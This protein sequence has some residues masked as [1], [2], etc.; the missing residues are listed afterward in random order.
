MKKVV[1][2]QKNKRTQN[3]CGDRVRL[4]RIKMR[5]HQIDLAAAMHVDYN[6]EVTRNSVSQI[7]CNTRNVKDFEL[8]VL[9]KILKVNPLWLLFG[10]N[11]P[12][13]YNLD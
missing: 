2:M 9:S 12:K 8:I 10:D 3:V 7:E 6:L 13:E 4:A 11:I 1:T 5:M